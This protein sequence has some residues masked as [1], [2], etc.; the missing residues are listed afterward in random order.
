M[1]YTREKENLIKYKILFTLFTVAVYLIGK[2]L[3]LYMIDLSAY[4]QKGVSAE[5]VLLQAI[6]GDTYRYSLFALGISPYMISSIFTQ[7]LSALQSQETRARI[8]TRKVNKRTMGMTLL[9]SVLMAVVQVQE[10]H[11]KVS[12]GYL[13]LLVQV[14]AAMEM[15]AGAMLIIWLANRNKKFGIG[16]QSALIFVN[17]LDSF[18]ANLKGHTLR[19]LA[20]P[21]LLTLM[22]VVVMTILEN[23]EK[24]IPVQRIS[25][26]NIYADKNYLAIKMNPIGIM[27]AMFSMAVFM[28]MQLVVDMAGW[29]LKDNP[30][31][32][33]WQENMVLSKPLGIL[34]YVIGLYALAIGFSRVFLNPKE[35]TEQFLK[36]GDSI[37][38]I[39]AGKETK[40][41]LSRIITGLAFFSATMMAICLAF[42]L[43][44]QLTGDVEGSLS[45]L[46]SSAMMLTGVIC[47]L[48][49]E[50]VAIRHLEAYKPFI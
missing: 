43:I 21:L 37:Q 16:G 28:L 47:N 12:E 14:V 25:V 2:S 49:R 31:Y 3:P 45:A 10:L 32:L 26:H 27:P 19:E 34:M 11:F 41:Y 48:G 7:I 1:K 42:P 18:I 23:A 44:L 33:W 40:R 5:D 39:H 6:S 29:F 17:I 38:N 35:T 8:S 9:F 22:A 50:F 46:P 20:I 4:V 15:I 30:T 24:R 36:S 13:L